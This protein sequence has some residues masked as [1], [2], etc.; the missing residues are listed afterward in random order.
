MPFN[1]QHERGAI[2]HRDRRRQLIDMRGLAFGTIT[3]TDLDG[4]IDYHDEAFAFF[5]L[6]LR[7][8]KLE[9]GQK[10]ALVRV[11][12]RIAASGARAALFVADHSIDDPMR[13]IAADRCSVRAIYELGEWRQTA[14]MQTLREAVDAFLGFAPVPQRP[15]EN[16]RPAQPTLA[17]PEYVAAVEEFNRRYLAMRSADR[18]PGEEG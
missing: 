14:A 11:V 1:A 7:G 17:D 9:L 6:K 16:A 5:E 10:L 3:P 2:R 13:D 15:R 4:L 8:Q 12:D 18:E